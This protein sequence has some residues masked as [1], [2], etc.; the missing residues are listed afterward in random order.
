LRFDLSTED[1]LRITGNQLKIKEI[2]VEEKG[3][4][5]HKKGLTKNHCEG[6]LREVPRGLR[7]SK[8]PET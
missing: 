1:A 7:N 6:I 2:N 5:D 4:G 3:G 8:P